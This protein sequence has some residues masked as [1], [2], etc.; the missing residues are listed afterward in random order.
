VRDDHSGLIDPGQDLVQRVGED[1]AFGQRALRGDAV[2]PRGGR[3]DG[4]ALRANDAGSTDQFI[5]SLVA[6]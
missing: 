2:N 4:V 5:A 3:G 6:E 1:N